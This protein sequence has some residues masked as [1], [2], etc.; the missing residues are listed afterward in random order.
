MYSKEFIQNKI[1]TDD[2]WLFRTLE[3][4]YN[5]QTTEEQNSQSTMEHNNRGFTGV[6][7]QILS[8][9]QEQVVKNRLLNKPSLL[10]PKQMDMCRKKLPKY[11][12]QVQQ[13]IKT[14]EEVGK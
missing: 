2:R 6:D 8:S 5:R 7:G 1:K 11:W 13:E 3:V 10:S 14:K 9:F 4:I 12:K